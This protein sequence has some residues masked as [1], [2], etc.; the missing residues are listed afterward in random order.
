MASFPSAKDGVTRGNQVAF[1][2]KFE[3]AKG[4]DKILHGA[5]VFGVQA[6]HTSSTCTTCSA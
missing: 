3:A 2:E 4:F 1:L 6:L 5:D